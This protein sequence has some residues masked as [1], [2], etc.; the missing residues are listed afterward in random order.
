MTGTELWVVRNW[1]MEKTSSE[2]HPLTAVIV[3]ILNEEIK[4][5]ILTVGVPTLSKTLPESVAELVAD[6]V[7]EGKRIATIKVLRE[8][9]G[10]GLKECKDFVELNWDKWTSMV[11]A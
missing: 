9:F 5:N 2:S 6:L 8:I 7:K 10:W 11:S 3:D 1:L 4:E